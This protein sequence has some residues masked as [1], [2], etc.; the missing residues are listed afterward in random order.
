MPVRS[1][2][3]SHRPSGRAVHHSDDLEL[4]LEKGQAEGEHRDDQDQECPQTHAKA[5]GFRTI[6]GSFG[7]CPGMGCSP[8][9]TSP[10]TFSG[11][12]ASLH[13]DSPRICRSGLG[14]H[15]R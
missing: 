7:S 11:P 15:H 9:S 14:S 1:A 6:A 8:S 4:T 13:G 2:P 3:V 5:L 12:A 10:P